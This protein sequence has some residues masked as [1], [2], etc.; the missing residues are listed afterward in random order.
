MVE[1]SRPAP[2]HDTP[3]N[4]QFLIVICDSMLVGAIVQSSF[5]SR[6]DN[7]SMCGWKPFCVWSSTL[8]Q[9]LRPHDLNLVELSRTL[10]ASET[11]QRYSQVYPK[12]SDPTFRRIT[13]RSSRALDELLTVR[14]K[15]RD[16]REQANQYLN[17]ARL[18]PEGDVQRRSV[19]VAQHY[20]LLAEAEASNAGR[21]GNERRGR[22]NFSKWKS[23]REH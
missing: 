17:R 4:T 22:W 1:C 9:I 23:Q 7:D 2:R 19:D 21:L 15:L 10:P 18:E 6:A 20:R 5:D 8:I 11:G 14:A 3:P 12:G 13:R 16:F